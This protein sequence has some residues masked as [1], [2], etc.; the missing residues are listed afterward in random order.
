MSQP[1]DIQSLGIFNNVDSQA[2]S[3]KAKYLGNNMTKL[4]DSLLQ[5]SEC[6]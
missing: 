5:A 1:T 3:I 6:P 2:L 4:L